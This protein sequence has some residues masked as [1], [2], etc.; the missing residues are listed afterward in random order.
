MYYML[1]QET[2]T[3]QYTGLLTLFTILA[4][5][6]NIIVIVQNIFLCQNMFIK[7]QDSFCASYLPTFQEENFKHSTFI[8]C[9]L[10][11]FNSNVT[12]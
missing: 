6:M 11:K 10:N 9:D 7:H 8:K 4:N 3:K 1:G 2:L 12:S 5:Q